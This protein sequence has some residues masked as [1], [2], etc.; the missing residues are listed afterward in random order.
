MSPNTTQAVIDALLLARK[1]GAQADALPLAE[2]LCDAADA[3]AVQTAVASQLPGDAGMPRHWKSGGP[4]RELPL[5]YAPLPPAGVW[6]SPATAG[7]WPLHERGIEIEIALRLGVAV[8]A[9]TAQTLQPDAVDH[10]IDAM[11]VSIEIVDSRWQQGMAAAPLLRLADFQSHGALVLGDW[12]PYRRRDW[13]AQTCSVTVGAQPPLRRQGSHSLGD[14]TWLLPQW[15][16]RACA[17]YG[18]VPAGTVV[19]TGTWV[20]IVPAQRGDAV[21]AVFEGIGEA[22]VQL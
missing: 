13:A 8:D 4:S 9:A 16:Q 14:P 7:D 21:L 18:T 15:L 20:G 1:Q 3:Y 2:A 12:L 10:L 11:A 6:A 17:L 5:T 19:T 22:R